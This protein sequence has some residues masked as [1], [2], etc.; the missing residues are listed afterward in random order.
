MCNLNCAYCQYGLT[1]G[2]NRRRFRSGSWPTPPAV[3]AAVEARLA[4]AAA[5]NELI[6]RITVA[7]H[8]EPTLHPEFEL[9]IEQLCAARDRIA[10]GIPVAILSNSTTAA[11]PEVR[12]AL[13]RFDERYMKL[14][15]GDPIT[16]SLINGPGASIT[17]VVDG[18]CGIP[19]ITI[20]SMFVCD[21]AGRVD[22]TTVGAVSEWLQALERIR[23]SC[24]HV[25][26]IDR[27]PARAGLY[28]VPKRRLRE[29]CENVRS[30]GF[31]AA[32][33]DGDA[34]KK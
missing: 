9:V 33:F 20:Q 4:R 15:A 21:R 22:N 32:V 13:A 28:A 10:P 18:L 1:R 30:A 16:Y 3:E 12:K 19:N 7:G 8:G 34:W 27:P 17:E 29:I 26:S 11:W 31:T 24:V 14:D 25:Y 23:P 5:Q 2:A 6:D